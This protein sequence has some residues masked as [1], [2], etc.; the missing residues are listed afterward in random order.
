MKNQFFPRQI[1]VIILLTSILIGCNT[2]EQDWNNA[3]Q[4]NSKAKYQEFMKNHS[5]SIFS[6]SAQKA[7]DS[8]D[9]IAALKTHNVDSMELFLK[10]HASSKYLLSSNESMDSIEWNIAI[11]SKDTTKL[12]NY[13]K[14]YPNSANKQKADNLI[15]EIKWPP[16]KIDKANSIVIATKKGGHGYG[17]QMFYS[18]SNGIASHVGGMAPEVFIW[19]EFSDSDLEGAKKLGL[20]IGLAYLH[21]YPN[22]FTF[23]RKVDLN[24][25]DKQLCEEFGVSSK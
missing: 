6:E 3:K 22:K 12:F 19:R 25:T 11:Y 2:P 24:K 16:V 9:L 1:E 8:L 20:R 13:I 23:I 4:A 21:E 14:K 10:N 7:I 17:T 15:W 5:S 18:G